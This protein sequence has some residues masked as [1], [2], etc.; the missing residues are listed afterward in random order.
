MYPITMG[1]V[2]PSFIFGTTREA[3]KNRVNGK[4]GVFPNSTILMKAVRAAIL[5]KAVRAAILMKAVRAAN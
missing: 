2:P 4:T 5:M 1:L 3:L